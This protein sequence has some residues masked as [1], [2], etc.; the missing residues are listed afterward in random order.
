MVEAGKRSRRY[1][2]QTMNARGRLSKR[3]MIRGRRECRLSGSIGNGELGVS[4]VQLLRVTLLTE[5]GFHR[6][7][8]IKCALNDCTV[9]SRA[10]SVITSS[11][12]LQRQPRNHLGN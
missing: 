3:R 2:T 12:A 8:Q 4:S 5:V 11:G 7:R 9:G 10:Q 6:L 1:D